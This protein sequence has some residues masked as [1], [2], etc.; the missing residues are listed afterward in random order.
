MGGGKAGLQYCSVVARQG[1]I[2]P[3]M[4]HSCAVGL[5][6]SGGCSRLECALDAP[7]TGSGM[8]WPC[9][10]RLQHP[11]EMIRVVKFLQLLQLILHPQ[12]VLGVDGVMHV[13]LWHATLCLMQRPPLSCWYC[14]CVGGMPLLFIAVACVCIR[15]L[16]AVE[17][18]F[19]CMCH[20]RQSPKIAVDVAADLLTFSCAG[21]GYP[22]LQLSRASARMACSV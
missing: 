8:T 17:P 6:A 13:V 20:Q 9:P 12:I 3:A 16:S 22:M 2:T 1:Y 4:H 18:C 14:C 19:F 7:Q 11:M 10:D 5:C 15:E 21:A